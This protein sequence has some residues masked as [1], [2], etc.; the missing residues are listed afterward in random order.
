MTPTPAATVTAEEAARQF[1]HENAHLIGLRE[2]DIISFVGFTIER[3]E[4]ATARERMWCADL[5][6]AIAGNR[7]TVAVCD[8]LFEAI[9][10]PP[11]RGEG[12]S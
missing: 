4:A 3:E 5:V 9:R 12:K 6:S 7:D 11:A 8:Y 2:M 10:Q 1:I